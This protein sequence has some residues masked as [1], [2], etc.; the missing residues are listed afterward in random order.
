[1]RATSGNVSELHGP[2]RLGE[3]R[4]SGFAAQ[5]HDLSKLSRARNMDCKYVPQAHP[6]Y[7]KGS[8]DIL[9]QNKLVT[10]T[11]RFSATQN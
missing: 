9:G 7:S 8:A 5:R 11:V 3:I 2:P 1:M 4:V 6:P 10:S